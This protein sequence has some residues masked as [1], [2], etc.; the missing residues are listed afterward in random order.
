MK[1]HEIQIYYQGTNME[2]FKIICYTTNS[3]I[4]LLRKPNFCPMCGELINLSYKEDQ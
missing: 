2:M 1:N 4:D 3:Y